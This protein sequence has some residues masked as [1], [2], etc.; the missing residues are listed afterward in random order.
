MSCKSEFSP[1]CVVNLNFHHGVVYILIFTMAWYKCSAYKSEFSSQ[2]GVNLNF[3]HMW[4]K[5]G[6]N[7]IFRPS[8][9]MFNFSRRSQQGVAT[10]YFKQI[11][12]ISSISQSKL[13]GLSPNLHKVGLIFRHNHNVSK[14]KL[15]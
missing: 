15:Y 5:C 2:C 6:V 13:K 10:L 14:K 9:G 4:C 8:Q 7:L 12:T 1:R 3:H 11:C